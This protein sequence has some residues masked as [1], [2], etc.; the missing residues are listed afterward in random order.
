MGKKKAKSPA[1]QVY[2]GEWLS[3][4]DI[5]LMTPSQEGAYIRLLFI[6]WLSDDCG[7][8]DDDE[9]LASLSRLGD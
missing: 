6:A 3:S 9:Q 1:F 7:L 5:M 8:P 2:P 4:Q